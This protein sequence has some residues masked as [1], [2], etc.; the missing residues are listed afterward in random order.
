MLLYQFDIH[1]FS[2]Y[3]TPGTKVVS[4]VVDHGGKDEQ[5][6]QVVKVTIF[7]DDGNQYEA[8]RLFR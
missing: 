7:T 5:G 8:T 3:L 4:A 6:R 2:F 1:G